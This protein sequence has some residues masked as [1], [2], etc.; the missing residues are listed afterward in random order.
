VW[1]AASARTAPVDDILQ[2]LSAAGFEF[3][4]LRDDLDAQAYRCRWQTPGAD[5]GQP[6]EAA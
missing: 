5:T 3:G 4:F 1:A 6:R 2:A